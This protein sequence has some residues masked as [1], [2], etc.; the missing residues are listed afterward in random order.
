MDRKGKTHEATDGNR[1]KK[2]IKKDAKGSERR[3]RRR[4]EASTAVRVISSF[5]HHLTYSISIPQVSDKSIKLRSTCA[6]TC[7]L[8]EARVYKEFKPEHFSICSL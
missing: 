8:R 2:R 3:R 6:S 7:W 4:R 5:F 1:K